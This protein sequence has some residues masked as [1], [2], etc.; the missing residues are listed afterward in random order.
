MISKGAGPARLSDP[1]SLSD[2]G[3]GW[4]G[5]EGFFF[6]TL[7]KWGFGVSFFFCS[8]FFFLLVLC[9]AAHFFVYWVFGM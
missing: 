5:A 1:A 7:K 8:I 6:C 9:R 4:V 3:D 2:P